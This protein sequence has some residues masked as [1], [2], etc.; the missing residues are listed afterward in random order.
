MQKS[1]RGKLVVVALLFNILAGCSS[2]GSRKDERSTEE[3]SA[4]DTVS[5]TRDVVKKEPVAGYDIPLKDDLNNWHFTVKL[6]ETK[7]R[8]NYLLDMQYQEVTASDTIRFPNFGY[9]P[10]PQIQKGANDNECIIG[11]LDKDKKFREYIKVFVD[12]DQFRLKQLK[13]YAVYSK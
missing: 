4:A 2:G 6:F 8:F 7:Q 13:Q 9:E 3:I 12:N 11:F 5:V 10:K 1:A